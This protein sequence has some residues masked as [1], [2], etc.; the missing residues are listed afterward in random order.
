MKASL[1]LSLFLALVLPAAATITELRLIASPGL[2]PEQ[3]RTLKEGLLTRVLTEVPVDTKVS[4]HDGWHL[5]EIVR[6]TV[7]AGEPAVRKRRLR[8]ELIRLLEWFE[9]VEQGTN[10]WA[11]AALLRLPESLETVSRGAGPHTAIVFI[12]SPLYFNPAEPDLSFFHPEAGPEQEHRLPGHGLLGFTYDQSLWGVLD[13]RTRLTGATVHLLYPS[14]ALFPARQYRSALREFLGLYLGL[15]NSRLVSFQS[16]PAELFRQW[17]QPDLEPV[18]R[19]HVNPTNAPYAML[20]FER[21]SLGGTLPVPAGALT[22]DVS[23]LLPV[24]PTN[25]VPEIEPPPPPMAPPAK[26]DVMERFLE[27]TRQ[28]NAPVSVGITWEQPNVDLDLYV[29]EG[30]EK[31]PLFFNHLTNRFGRFLMDYRDATGGG[32]EQVILHQGVTPQYEAWVNVHAIQ[33]ELDRPITGKTIL[34]NFGRTEV[35]RFELDVRTGNQGADR[36]GRARSPFWRKVAVYSANGGK[37][38]AE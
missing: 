11:G 13:V 19:Y 3:A 15:Q 6:F 25:T 10:A 34:H 7:P 27:A 9:A 26:P 20:R 17:L 8:L 5:R 38:V 31:L 4:L 22:P 28:H 1:L 33:G 2:P 23:S 37:T 16:D 14:E 30:G 35:W 21:N 32:L 36:D 12:G 24:V 29:F 18:G